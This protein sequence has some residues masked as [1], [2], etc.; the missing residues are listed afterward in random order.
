MLNIYYP[1]TYFDANVTLLFQEI[2]IRC[3]S[4]GRTLR[5]QKDFIG[6]EQIGTQRNPIK[7][8]VPLSIAA[9]IQFTYHQ[10]AQI[11]SHHVV[12]LIS[13]WSIYQLSPTYVIIYARVAV[14][15]NRMTILGRPL[16]LHQ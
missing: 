12:R 13:A 9:N 11:F 1:H 15:N 2:C 10:N 6:L 7:M 16:P 4:Y 5:N 8:P 3:I 14:T